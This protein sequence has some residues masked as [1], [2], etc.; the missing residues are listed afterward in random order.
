MYYLKLC[1]V[2]HKLTMEDSFSKILSQ[3]VSCKSQGCGRFGH[4]TIELADEILIVGGTN[5]S[6]EYSTTILKF[7]LL[8]H[9]L[10]ELVTENNLCIEGFSVFSC[11]NALFLWGG[12]IQT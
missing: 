1:F 2:C 8:S 9:R 5:N 6:S 11:Q 12:N 3:S 10:D 7:N 4:R